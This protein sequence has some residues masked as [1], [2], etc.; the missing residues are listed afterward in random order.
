MKRILM[1]VCTAALLLPVGAG[2]AAAA[3]NAQASC[4]AQL[5]P[6]LGTP[7]GYQREAHDPTVG[8]RMVSYLA[9]FHEDCLA[10]PG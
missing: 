1:L 4:V 2:P 6:E 5:I 10:I 8:Q 3:P 9:H 7:G